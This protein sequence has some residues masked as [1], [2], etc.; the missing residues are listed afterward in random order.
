[1]YYD[2]SIKANINPDKLPVIRRATLALD[3][4]AQTLTKMRTDSTTREKK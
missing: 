3:E 1:M 2:H 4:A